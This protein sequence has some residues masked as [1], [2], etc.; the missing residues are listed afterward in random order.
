M[1]WRC[2]AVTAAGMLVLSGCRGAGGK[3]SGAEAN[4]WDQVRAKIQYQAARQQFDAGKPEDA[5]RSAGQALALDP[6]FADAYL[7]L[8]QAQL[9]ARDTFGALATIT[10]ARAAGLDAPAFDYLEGVAREQQGDA[11]AALAAYRRARE[12]TPQQ[13]DYLAA[14]VELTVAQGAPDAALELLH[15]RVC[16]AGPD[17]TLD[18]L[19]A[20]LAALT[21]DAE[22]AE[23]CFRSAIRKTSHPGLAADFGLFLMRERRYAEARGILE[24]L[25]AEI[26]GEAPSLLV[27]NAL[28]RCCLA[29]GD[30]GAAYRVLLPRVNRGGADV[31]TKLLLA[32]AA[33]A[34]GRLST[35]LKVCQDVLN[36]QPEHASA[37]LLRAAAYR[38]Q[39]NVNAAQASLSAIPPSAPEFGWARAFGAAMSATVAPLESLDRGVQGEVASSAP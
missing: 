28:A 10:A 37:L 24:P 31:D 34:S 13:A 18:A 14:E 12:R 21:G 35:A 17:A 7:L 9:E 8:A 20:R 1:S 15:P 11:V 6:K 2:A 33:L 36:E 32:T 3:E 22:L 29:L 39:G 4:R 23:Q 38:R 25:T 19:G 27:C 16:G 5:V 30:A 26:A